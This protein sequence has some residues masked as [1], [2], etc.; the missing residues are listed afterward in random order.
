MDKKEKRLA[1]KEE[2]RPYGVFSRFQYTLG[3]VVLV[4]GLGFVAKLRP[5]SE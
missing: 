3:D 2:H 1:V 5:G 4:G